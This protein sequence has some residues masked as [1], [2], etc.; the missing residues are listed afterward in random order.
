[1]RLKENEL[2]INKFGQIL[3]TVVRS[4]LTLKINH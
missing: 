3:L 2:K 1:M 4:P